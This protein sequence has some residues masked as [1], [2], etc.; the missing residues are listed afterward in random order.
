MPRFRIDD[1]L[2][3]H[4]KAI[5]AGDEAMGMWSRGGS[6]SMAYGT[7]GFIPDWWIAQQN[8]G[9][10]KAKRLE[11]AGLWHRGEYPGERAEFQGLT[12]YNYHDW[13]QDSYE[14]VEAD[15]QKW[16]IKKAAQRGMSPDMSPR[17]T[18]GDSPGDSRESPGY[19]PN[20]HTQKKRTH[21]GSEPHVSNA[22]DVAP[23]VDDPRGGGISATPGADLVRANVPK[24]HPDPTLTALR[25]QASELVNTGTDPDT[26][27]AALRLWCDKPGVGIG[28][29]ILSSLCSEVIK[30]RNG[31]VTRNG[32]TTS[33]TDAKGIGWLQFG[34]ERDARAANQ[35]P[36][37]AALEA[38]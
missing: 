3:S 5:T 19:I 13:R 4:P 31:A 14:K 2:H 20:T 38:Q 16:R 33:T 26:V 35:T 27:A 34:Q 12:G 24:G 30:S 9:K 28:R 29:T 23:P 25:L 36:A 32:A 6:W 17:D 22:R 10:V 1:D 15:R 21:L 18:M 37:I 7:D 8:R 11:N